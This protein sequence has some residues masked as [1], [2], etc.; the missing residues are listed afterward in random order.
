MGTGTQDQPAVSSSRQIL[1]ALWPTPKVNVGPWTTTILG[2]APAGVTP[3]NQSTGTQND[4][5][6][7]D[8]ACGAGTFTLDMFHLTG[9]NRGIYTIAIDGVTKGTVDG[10]AA[11]S[12]SAVSTLTGIVIAA[13]AHTIR[14][15]MATQNVSSSNY[16]G[17]MCEA[18]LTQTV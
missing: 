10:Y 17:T 13:G 15:T 7:F 12:G 9:T 16:Y 1:I 18:V 2:L 8:F 11:A 3:Y 4:A 14:F 5:A 6:T